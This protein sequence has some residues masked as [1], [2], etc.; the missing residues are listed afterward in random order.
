MNE[1]MDVTVAAGQEK[2]VKLKKGKKKRPMNRAS[3]VPANCACSKVRLH[4]T[5]SNQRGSGRIICDTI[6]YRIV[7]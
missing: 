5:P 3:L 7:S 4:Y 6:L 2:I 1:W